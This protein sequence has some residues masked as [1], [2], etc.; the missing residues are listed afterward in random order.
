LLSG[1]VLGVEST[2]E[3]VAAPGVAYQ[4]L[5]LPGPQTVHVVSFDLAR[6][7]LTL[8]ATAGAGVRGKETVPEMVAGLAP[9][10]GRS[11][12][13]IN[14]DYFE[15]QGEPR[16]FG[17]VQGMC[18]AAGELIA[19]PPAAAFWVDRKGRPHLGSVASRLT[20]TWPDRRETPGLPPTRRRAPGNGC[21]S[22]RAPMRRGSPCGLTRSIPP[23]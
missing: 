2:V 21:W 17:T 19:A 3:G 20:V 10:R 15:F 8:A 14:G 9:S 12:V 4:R 5:S 22:A 11:V 6:E 18:I 23:G 7:G 1:P 13:A 16:Y